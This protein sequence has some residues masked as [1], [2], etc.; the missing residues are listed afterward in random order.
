MRIYIYLAV[1]T[2]ST[3]KTFDYSPRHWTL[4]PI[5]KQKTIKETFP[6][7]NHCLQLMSLSQPSQNGAKLDFTDSLILLQTIIMKNYLN[8]TLS[9]FLQKI[10]YSKVIHYRYN[11]AIHHHHILHE[12]RPSGLF[13]SLSYFCLPN[14]SVIFQF[15]FLSVDIANSVF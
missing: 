10:I 11:V 13:R 15:S 3:L 7:I 2:N 9:K 12:Y 5:T 1:R 8:S 14:V 4:I 6:T